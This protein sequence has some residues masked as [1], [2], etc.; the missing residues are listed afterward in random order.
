MGDFIEKFNLI[1]KNYDFYALNAYSAF[2]KKYSWDFM[3]NNLI[4]EYNTLLK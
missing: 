2:K 4:N 1:E 3:I